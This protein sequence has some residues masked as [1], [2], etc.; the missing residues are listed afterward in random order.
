[1]KTKKFEKKLS[2]KKQTITNLGNNDMVRAN[3]GKDD[4]KTVSII[5]ELTCLNTCPSCSPSCTSC[6]DPC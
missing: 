2:F 5:F 3:A 4:E 6:P 1:M